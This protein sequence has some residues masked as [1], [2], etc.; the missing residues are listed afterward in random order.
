MKS[1]IK[2]LLLLIA[3]AM[4]TLA[5]APYYKFWVIFLSLPLLMHYINSAKT[6]W[7]AFWSGW[8]FAFAH[9]VTGLYW[10]SNSMLVEADKFAWMI[11]FAVSVL[12]AILAIYIGIAAYVTQKSQLRG[13]SQIVY[14]SSFWVFMEIARSN[15][16][17]GFSWNLA[18]QIFLANIEIAQLASIIGVYGLSFF[19]IYVG[20]LPY[21]VINSLFKVYSIV[22]P[23]KAGIQKNKKLDPDF[24]RDDTTNRRL[25]KNLI[26][27]N[28]LP[29]LIFLIA[30]G[31]WGQ[32]RIQDNSTN[33]KVR[34]VQPNIPQ[35]ENM[36]IAHVYKNIEKHFKLTQVKKGE[37]VPSIIVWSESS[38]PFVLNEEPDFAKA[39]AKY[40]PKD[41]IL[42]TGSNRREGEKFYNS[43]E[44]LNDKGEIVA[45]YNKH[46]LV[47]Y[48][49][50]VPLRNIF[51][52][53][54][55]ITQGM[56]DFT[57]GEGPKT[58]RLP[59]M[60]AFAPNICYEIIF[61]SQIIDKNS[62]PDF[63]LNST[64]DAWFGDST[65][66]HQHLAQTQMRAIEE[67]LPVLRSANTGISAVIDSYGRIIKSIPLNVAGVIN[68]TLPAPTPPTPFSKYGIM[69]S[70]I[71][72]GIFAALAIVFGRTKFV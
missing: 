4:F 2:Y 5:F 14:F 37:D 69:I 33:T 64:N 41:S 53:I 65:G 50:Y 47:P 6:P 63:I 54:E 71:M 36:D 17:T 3:G 15:I 28:L 27:F 59:A 10:I 32:K 57:A 62:R 51:P 60:P 49:E 24:R 30:I 42:A 34:I 46:H 48:G 72:C 31:V 9:H 12:P 39:I 40:I 35:N 58:I 23:A 61:P 21:S 29:V 56:G 19:A 55:K 52:F 43:I 8:S 11:P 16:L 13:A 68:E 7:A 66:P 44:V 67:G 25:P 38:S 1:L 20:A 70:V 45:S 26:L 22:I 18:G